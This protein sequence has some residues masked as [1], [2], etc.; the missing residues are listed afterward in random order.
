MARQRKSTTSPYLW[1]ALYA[2]AGYYGYSW[3]MNRQQQQAM[4]APVVVN[5]TQ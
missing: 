2:V 4:I 5:P 1:Y 3:W